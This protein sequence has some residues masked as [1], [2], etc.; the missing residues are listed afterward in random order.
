MKVKMFKEGCPHKGCT[1]THSLELSQESLESLQV[2]MSSPK[3]RVDS[4]II[5]TF[6]PH[7]GIFSFC[8]PVKVT[9]TR[10]EIGALARQ[11]EV[12]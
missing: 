11:A 8:E 5:P 1:E 9:L 12:R 2:K 6:C 4:V 10:D 3:R 7:Y